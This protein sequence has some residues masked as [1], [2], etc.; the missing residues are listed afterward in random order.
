MTA[1]VPAREVELSKTVCPPQRFATTRSTRNP[2]RRATTAWA[3]SWTS[4]DS[5]SSTA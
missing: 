2:N 1:L 4:T 5:S 3:A